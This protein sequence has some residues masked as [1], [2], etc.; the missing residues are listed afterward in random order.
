MVLDHRVKLFDHIDLADFF[1]KLFDHPHRQGIHHP[2]L[3]DGY[4][5]AEHLFDILVRGRGGDNAEAAACVAFFDTVD[6]GAFGKL[7][8]FFGALFHKRMTFDGVR[9]RHNIFLGVLFIRL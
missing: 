8:Q 4:G 2:E 3:Q 5:V 7:T 6:A 9:G 1:G